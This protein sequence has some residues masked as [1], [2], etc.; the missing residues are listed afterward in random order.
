MRILPPNNPSPKPDKATKK[1]LNGRSGLTFKTKLVEF[2]LN[3]K[4]QACAFIFG[5]LLLLFYAVCTGV[6]LYSNNT[7]TPETTSILDRIWQ[8]FLLCLGV[9]IGGKLNSSKSED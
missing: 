4:A 6:V 9:M 1:G 3:D 8:A 5:A 2:C 7:I